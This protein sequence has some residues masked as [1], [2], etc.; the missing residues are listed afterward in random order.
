MSGVHSGKASQG[1]P[2]WLQLQSF[3]IEQGLAVASSRVVEGE[4]GLGRWERFCD[5]SGLQ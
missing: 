3:L 1:P 2:A 4:S 5:I